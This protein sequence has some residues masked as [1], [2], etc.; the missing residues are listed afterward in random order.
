VLQMTI[1]EKQRRE[2][3]CYAILKL[4]EC[5]GD[6]FFDGK[7]FADNDPD[8]ADVFST[9][10]EE[11]RCNG[12]LAGVQGCFGEHA[13]YKLTGPGWIEGLRLTGRLND[14]ALHEQL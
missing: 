2:N 9:T 12:M 10:W 13:R 8:F 14:P 7:G 1:S 6:D 11:L 5:I 4:M 3:Q